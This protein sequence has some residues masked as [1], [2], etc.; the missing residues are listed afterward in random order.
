MRARGKDDPETV[1]TARRT[2]QTALA[3]TLENHGSR[4]RHGNPRTQKLIRGLCRAA[5]AGDRHRNTQVLQ[6]R[7]QR[8]VPV[9][10][11]VAAA[12]GA[13]VRP[14]ADSASSC[15]PALEVIV[16]V[17]VFA[18]EILGEISSFYETFPFWDTVLHTM[19][20]FLAAAI[21]FSLVH[22]LNR[23][24][25][26]EVRAVAAVPGDRLLLLLHDHRRGLGVLRIRAWT[27]LF[28]FDM[29]K[30]AVVHS[31]SSVMLD[32]AHANH[33]DSH[34]RHH[35]GRGQWPRPRPRRLPRHRP[36][37][38]DGGSHRQLHRRGRVLRHRLH[39]REEPRQEKLHH[40]PVRTPTQ[41]PR[42]RLPATGD[43]WRRRG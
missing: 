19:N 1:A 8:R 34:Q 2:T 40:Q 5:H 27:M 17:F 33:A 38:H 28:G 41:I 3:R 20:G 42:P 22:L 43:R 21:G 14:G 36:D 26:G 32:P 10:P 29:Q 35:P 6:R 25:P 11:D 12:A 30:D 9:H 24:G 23:S 16:L 7:R 18:A 39:L 4:H 15:R 37:R 31:I 13:R